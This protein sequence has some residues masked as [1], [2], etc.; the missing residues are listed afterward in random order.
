[1]KKIGTAALV[2]LT[3]VTLSTLSLGCEKKA[4]PAK[5]ANSTSTPA[6]KPAGGH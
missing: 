3:A 5:P 6:E 1:M 4:E 2:V